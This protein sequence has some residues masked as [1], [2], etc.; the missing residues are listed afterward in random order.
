MIRQEVVDWMHRHKVVEVEVLLP[1]LTGIPRGKIIPTEKFLLDTVKL[2][3]SVIAQAVTGEWGLQEDFL[4]VTDN[5]MQL[6]PDVDG[7]FVIPWAPADEPAAQVVCDCYSIRNRPVS[8]APRTLLK[9]V[10]GLFRRKGWVPVVAPEIEFYFVRHDSNPDNPLQAPVGRSEWPV[11]GQQP[12]SIDAVNEYEPIVNRIYS[13]AEQQGLA[14]DT[15]N[16]EDGIAQMEI[17]FHHGD[18]VA[19]ADQVL[20]FKRCV[21]EAAIRHKVRA[22]FMAKPIEG[23]PGSSLHIHQSVR[24][25]GGD[26]LFAEQDGSASALMMR[27]LAGLQRHARAFQAVYVPNINS[28]RR[29]NSPRT[30]V[31]T[32]WGVN[33]RSVGFRIPETDDVAARRI[34][35]RLP[36]ADVNPYLAMAASLLSGYLGM[37]GQAKPTDECRGAGWDSPRGLASDLVGAVQSMQKS[38]VARKMLGGSFVN[39][40]T[41][42]KL[43]E[44]ENYRRVVSSWERMFLLQTV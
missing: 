27:Y 43:T 23:Q 33:N 39:L 38:D 28:Y 8:H 34:E 25:R 18:P 40:Y 19:M 29:L 31:N 24:S 12:F 14:I 20:M 26:N 5:D 42:V 6:V 15:L 22:T 4:N 7:C 10:V 30:S 1:D 3:E 9:R 36:G 21:R 16:H 32:Q 13:Y 41:S 37:I 44:Y 35:N 17:N 2:P 11:G